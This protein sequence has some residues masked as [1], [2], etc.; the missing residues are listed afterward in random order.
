[1]CYFQEVLNMAARFVSKEKFVERV[2]KERVVNK[3][4]SWVD[5]KR[6][7]VFRI[8]RIESKQSQYGECWLTTIEDST[9]NQLKFFAPPGMIRKIKAERK[10]DEAVYFMSFGQEVLKIDHTKRNRYDI[11]F[12]KDSTVVDNLFVGYE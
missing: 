11:I 4:T 5:L 9:N 7:E 10:Y 2:E 3:T 12:Q 8:I 6:E 1:M